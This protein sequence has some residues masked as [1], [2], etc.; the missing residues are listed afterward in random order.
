MQKKQPRPQAKRRIMGV[1]QFFWGEIGP[2]GD[3]SESSTVS[4]LQVDAVS[5]LEEVG[6]FAWDLE[7]GLL[8]LS[9]RAVLILDRVLPGSSSVTVADL[10]R[11]PI[12]RKAHHL[13]IMRQ[14]LA[15]GD[16]HVQLSLIFNS[17]DGDR[18]Q[19]RASVRPMKVAGKIT[20]L[21]GAMIDQTA[22]RRSEAELRSTLST[23]PS[24]M[25]VIDEKGKIRA[26]SA[27]AERMFGRVA[28]YTI[29]EPIEILMPEP[30]R[31]EHA[32]YL[33]R[34]LTTGEARIIGQSRIMYAV[35]AD[36]S[37][38]PIELWV[39]DASTENER[40]F[41]GFIHDHSARFET[42]AKLQLLQNDLLHVARSSALGELSMALAHELN[43][44]LGAIVN[45][46][47]TADFLANSESPGNRQRLLK[48]IANAT[49]QSMRAGAII[50]RLRTFI[51]R[52]EGDKRIERVATIVHE[53]TSLL[54]SAIRQKG[55]LLRT[56][57]EE[58]RALI[59]ADRVQI[60]QVL[61][62]LLRNAMEALDTPGPGKTPSLSVT[63]RLLDTETIEIMVEDNGSGI[64]PDVEQRLFKPFTT[65]KPGGMGVGLSIS[66]RIM[67]AHGGELRYAASAGGGARFSLLLP[68][69]FD[70]E[71]NY[72]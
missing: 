40:L 34:Y 59:L 38:F 41:T 50:K 16:D 1:G 5:D 42:E 57:I 25:I 17:R 39:G 13:R 51:E 10:R 45:H 27:A 47:A 35:R 7:G 23:V 62:N 63:V 71:H 61:F 52:G 2:M 60:Q 36:G 70:E 31:S 56:V 29:G 26:F 66:R 48:T 20:Q 28:S 19:I 49:D 44:P 69:V 64:S 65:E 43:Q 58:K 54:S 72:V 22:H 55:I 30:Y 12:L 11:L 68:A 37:E 6:F 9:D 53:A 33:L 18:R 8:T 3:R 32:G 46:L 21:A 4:A 14:C 24:A 67:E 15:R